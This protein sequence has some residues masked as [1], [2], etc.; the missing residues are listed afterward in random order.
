MHTPLAAAAGL[1][2]LAFACSTYERWLASRRRHELAWSLAL[3]FF[4][5]GAFSLAAGA[6]LGWSPL[7]FR[8][9][10]LFG[11]IVNVPFLALGTVYLLGG[12]R[13]GDRVAAVVALLAAFAAGVVLTS[14][15]TAR[16][17]VDR[18]AQGSDVFGP[19]P[20]ILAAVSSGAGALTILLG[21]AWSA[22]RYRRGRMLW[23]NVLIAAGT[24][25][26]SS[27]GLLNSVLD[28]MDGFAVTLV[29]GISV[30]FAG[31]L[32]ATGNRKPAPLQA[33]PPTTVQDP[34]STSGRRRERQR[35]SRHVSG[36][37][38]LRSEPKL[39]QLASQELPAETDR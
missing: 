6:A 7:T 23:S 4:S 8:L 34:A 31:F 16:L 24:L 12:E 14:P 25:V 22:F 30:I 2:A 10:Y 39:R 9:F 36:A 15:L 35:A 20:R 37:A 1:V 3:G 29:V 28:E 19:A 38:S 21:A 33:V 13:R 26:L 18:L 11:A 5:V 17:P 27:S 32:V